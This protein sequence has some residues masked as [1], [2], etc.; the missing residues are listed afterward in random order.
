MGNPIARHLI[1]AGHQLVVH[2]R[3]AEAA[4]NLLE[5]GATW[6]DDPRSV[7]TQSEVVFTSL[8]G[9]PQVDEA[10]LGDDGI[11]AGAQ[12]G[13]I[14]VDLTT[15]LPSAVRRIAAIEEARGVSFLE[16]PLSGL[17]A[18]AE[19]GT[20]TIFVGGDAKTLEV[21]RPL[22]EA[23]GKT[24][25]HVGAIGRGNIMKLTNNMIIHAS[26]LLVQEALAL[27]VKA[28]FEPEELY[29]MWNAS[30][31]S[32]FV[33][34]I[35]TLLEGNYENPNFTL[36]LAAKDIGLC[37]EAGRDLAVPMTVASAA[38]QV[39]TRSVARGYGHLQRQGGTLLTI[40]AETGVEIVRNPSMG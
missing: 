30:S 5:L 12:G 24:I 14:H 35:P 16:A 3:R 25:F 1:R 18:G 20:L 10:V 36:A 29:E 11:L 13:T 28:G 6:A 37:V 23:F 31:S 17:V 9:P 2:D 27:G 8:P 32:R 26:A 21:V 15:N 39:Y 33:Q 22:L 38:S 19:A 7:A 40:Q 34:E 4:A